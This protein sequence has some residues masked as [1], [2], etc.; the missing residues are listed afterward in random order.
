[1]IVLV[2]SRPKFLKDKKIS[3]FFINLKS[4]EH[5]NYINT[6]HFTSNN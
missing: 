1:M 4:A 6:I 2:D 3:H 5:K